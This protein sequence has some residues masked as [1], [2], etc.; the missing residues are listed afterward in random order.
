M[1]LTHF[2]E[3]VNKMTSKCKLNKFRH[4]EMVLYIYGVLHEE[5]LVFIMQSLI[6]L[7]TII[8]SSMSNDF[9]AP[10]LASKGL[11]QE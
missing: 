5:K 8:A 11:F 6:Y 7:W 4:T 9:S 3:E 1:I 10:P 2:I